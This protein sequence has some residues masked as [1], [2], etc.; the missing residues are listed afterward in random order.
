[1]KNQSSRAQPRARRIIPITAAHR[2]FSLIVIR[3]AVTRPRNCEAPK[4]SIALRGRQIKNK[5]IID[6][7][8]TP[9]YIYLFYVEYSPLPPLVARSVFN[10]LLNLHAFRRRNV[11][12][13]TLVLVAI[14]VRHFAKIKISSREIYRCSYYAH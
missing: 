10:Y 4:H 2:N 6:L 9:I 12:Q 7:S 3:F 13:I 11:L 1:M 5:Y 14:L 8:A